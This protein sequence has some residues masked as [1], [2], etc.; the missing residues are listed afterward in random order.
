LPIA[1][2]SH[3]QV[4]DEPD[5]FQ[6]G[7]SFL[8]VV[9][10][11]FYT[12]QLKK[13]QWRDYIQQDN[14]VAAALLSKMGYTEHERVEVKKEFLRMLVRLELN[15]ARITLITGFFETYLQLDEA[16]MQ[17]LQQEIKKLDPKEEERIMELTTSWHEKGKL[18]G[19]LEVAKNMLLKGMD[20]TTIREITELPLEEIERLKKKLN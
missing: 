20:I 5:N 9:T 13:K 2:F 12:V 4:R 15:P 17:R 19:R 10:F 14:P 18:E 7:F 1:V 16:E 11:Q 6:L 3:D 8:D